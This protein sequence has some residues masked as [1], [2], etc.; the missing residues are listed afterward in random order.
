MNFIQYDALS[1]TYRESVSRTY[2][3]RDIDV[4]DE[5]SV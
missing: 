1:K 2:P 3:A 4:C 5:S